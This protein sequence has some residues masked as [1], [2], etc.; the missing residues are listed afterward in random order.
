MYRVI[1]YYYKVG[2]CMEWPQSDIQSGI[3]LHMYKVMYK[4][5]YYHTVMYRVVCSYT[6]YIPT[7]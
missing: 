7:R 2:W 1:G 6:E 5:V 4:V 3:F